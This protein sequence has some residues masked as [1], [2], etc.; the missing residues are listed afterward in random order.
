M[1]IE[2]QA[3]VMKQGRVAQR[4]ESMELLSTIAERGASPSIQMLAD[5]EARKPA[6][7]AT[8]AWDQA[9]SPVEVAD[10][11]THWIARTEA[12]RA[13]LR[14][15]SLSLTTLRREVAKGIAPVSI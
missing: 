3:E 13:A 15:I 4:S 12:T 1:E 6:A 9:E 7:S 5:D 2:Q 10:Y 14:A 11:L 8:S